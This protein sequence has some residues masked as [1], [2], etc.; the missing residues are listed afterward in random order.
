MPFLY[1]C[2]PVSTGSHLRRPI[3]ISAGL[4]SPKK[5]NVPVNRRQRYLNYGLLS[6]ANSPL[7]PAGSLFH[8]HFDS[9]SETLTSVERVVSAK[10]PSTFFISCPSFLSTA[11]AAEFIELAC[12]RF[13]NAKFIL[14]GRWVIDGNVNAIRQQMPDVD[15]IFE[16]IA[17]GRLNRLLPG[18]LEDEYFRADVAEKVFAETGLSYLDYSKLDDPYAFVPSFE[19]SRGCGAGC[20]F[21]AE[22]FVQLTKLKPPAVL[23]AEMADFH[24]CVP[25]AVRRFYLETSNFTPRLDWIEEFTRERDRL[26]LSDVTWR[27]EARVDMFSQRNIKALARAGLRVL[28]LG[29]ESASHRQLIRMGKT[30]HPD[31]YLSRCSQ[32]IRTAANHGIAIKLNVLLFPGEDH[33]TL[34]ETSDWLTAHKPYFVGVSAFPTIYYGFEPEKDPVFDY[35]KSLGARLAH[36]PSEKGI[37][38]IHLSSDIPHPLSETLARN[39]SRTFMTDQEY[40]DLKSFSYFDPRYTK[41][42]FL[43]DLA[44]SPEESLSFRKSTGP[45]SHTA[46]PHDVASTLAST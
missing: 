36:S 10:I 44:T 8:G 14:G 5:G 32:L 38:N 42:N 41:E 27:T 35:Y 3:F 43:A 30:K 19:G 2:C 12:A 33:S 15:L 40:F 37:F 1:A 23:C 20:K 21:C 24:R 25:E 34:R 26:G 17:E 39:L 6:V 13:D 4:H 29:L 22:A 46:E 31:S 18:L 11:W 7:V 16:G 28:D 9:P 45:S